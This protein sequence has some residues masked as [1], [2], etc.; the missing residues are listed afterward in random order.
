M[1][2]DVR[3][4]PPAAKFQAFGVDTVEVD[5]HDLQCLRDTLARVGGGS[6]PLAVV[7][8]T[9]KGCGVP[10]MEGKMDW[11][12]LPLNAQQYEAAVAGLSGPPRG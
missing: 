12:Y 10:F 6:G 4:V 1:K 7:A 8:R 9:K 11:H 3:K 2:P 5:G